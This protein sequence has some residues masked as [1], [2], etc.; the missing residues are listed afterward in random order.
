MSTSAKTFSRSAI[1]AFT[2]TYA[3]AYL[4]ASY[5]DLWTTHLA[6][7]LPHAAEANPFAVVEGDFS[8]KHAWIYTAIVGPIL[9][10]Y[11]LYGAAKLHRVTDE[12]LR[13][14]LRS[15]AQFG[16]WW[17]LTVLLS[18]YFVPRSDRAALHTLSAAIAFVVLRLLAAMNN[19]MIAVWGD[20]F[21]A[22]ALRP[23]IAALGP[24]AAFIV[25]ICGLYIVL[26]LLTAKLLGALVATSRSTPIKRTEKKM[27]HGGNR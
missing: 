13:R 11:V 23:V 14:P 6:L 8:A 18:V 4:T 16:G 10:A 21:L 12:H 19:A 2:I 1:V 17:G 25:V 9:I 3:A 5:L 24:L 15:Y 7:L 22:A 26:M 20:G 27:I